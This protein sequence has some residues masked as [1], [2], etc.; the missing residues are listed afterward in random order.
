MEQEGGKRN[1]GA[2]CWKGLQRG[3]GLGVSVSG[4]HP[5]EA[6]P[7]FILDIST[8]STFTTKPLLLP[9]LLAGQDSCGGNAAAATCL[10]ISHQTWLYVL[11]GGRWVSKELVDLLEADT[12]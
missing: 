9:A 8:I 5:Y 6:G 7:P 2:G 1:N 4:G 10:T 12:Y 11:Q 3:A